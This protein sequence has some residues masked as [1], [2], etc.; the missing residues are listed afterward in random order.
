MD[1]NTYYPVILLSCL[2]RNLPNS[3]SRFFHYAMYCYAL[4]VDSYVLTVGEII[5]Y[6]APQIQSYSL[7][8][9]RKINK[10]DYKVLFYL[11]IYISSEHKT[12][13]NKNVM[14]KFNLSFCATLLILF[15]FSSYN[16]P[17]SKYEIQIFEFRYSNESKTLN[18]FFYGNSKKILYPIAIQL[19]LH[20]WY[21]SYWGKNWQ[22]VSLK[23]SVN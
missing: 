23:H 1:Q 8:L 13:L 2:Q 17:L 4:T 6:H 16:L 5:D 9:I 21:L 18:N 14:Q 7:L 19:W 22:K 15:Y 12:A 10:H 20:D 3:I 11:I